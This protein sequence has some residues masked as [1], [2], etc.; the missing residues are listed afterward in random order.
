MKIFFL[1]DENGNQTTYSFNTKSLEDMGEWYEYKSDNFNCY[2]DKAILKNGVIEIIKGAVIEE[3]NI[4][5]KKTEKIAELQKDFNYSKKII[6]QNGKTLVIN[7]DTP[8]RTIFTDNLENLKTIG[9]NANSILSYRQKVGDVYL[10]FS[11]LS[12]IWNKLFLGKFTKER[13][14]LTLESKRAKNKETLDIQK[15]EIEKATSIKELEAITWSFE[16]ITIIN[17]NVEAQKLVDDPKTPQYVIDAIND[18]KDENGEIHLIRKIK[19]DKN[20]PK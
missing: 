3:R 1:F 8:E 14:S 6:L 17:I 7:H 11:A 20:K 12:Y 18:L 9:L 13:L 15:L 2:E 4:R 10:G 16:D 19:Y 5:R